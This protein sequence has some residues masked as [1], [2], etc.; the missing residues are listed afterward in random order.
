MYFAS[1]GAVHITC[2]SKADG[3]SDKQARHVWNFVLVGISATEL[4]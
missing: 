1:L 4:L 2:V 3:V